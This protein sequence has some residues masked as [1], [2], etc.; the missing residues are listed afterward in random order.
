MLILKEMLNYNF[1]KMIL[2]GR[3][4]FIQV[5]VILLKVRTMSLILYLFLL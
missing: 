5:A 2:S 4:Q 1:P 3:V